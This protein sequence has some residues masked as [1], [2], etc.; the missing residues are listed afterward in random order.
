MATYLVDAVALLRY[1]VDELPD[2]ADE[3]FTRGE[4]G[5]DV[6]R[7]PDVQV[8]E[9]L[10]QVANGGVVAGV[11]LQGTPDETFRRLVTNGPV[12][13][14]GIGELEL[15]VYASEIGLYSMHDGLLAATNR[16]QDTDAVITNDDAFADLDTVWKRR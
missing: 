16:V 6:L 4:Q 11:D 13:V 3:V 10:Y 1:L 9:V 14:A 7:A 15:R 12:D 5:V 8:A 2:G